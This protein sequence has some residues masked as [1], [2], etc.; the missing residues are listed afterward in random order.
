M[1]RIA[2][3]TLLDEVHS[4]VS[5]LTPSEYKAI[6]D[7]YA[8]RPHGYMFNPKYKAKIWDGYIRFFSSRGEVNIKLLPDIIKILKQ[9]GYEIKLIDRR[10]RVS[11]NVPEID[12]NYLSEFGWVLGDHQVELVNALIRN[13]GGIVKAGTGAG[14]TVCCWILHHLY[15]T[16]CGFRTLIIVPKKS[17]VKQ[18]AEE[19]NEFS[20]DVG[21]WGDN[22][23]DTDHPVVIS[24]WQTLQKHETFV[25]QF[26]H[27]ILDEC[28]TGKNFSGNINKILNKYGKQCYVK[29]GMTGTLPPDKCDMKTLNS[30]LGD[31]IYE[32]TAKH[33]IDIGWLASME[34][35]MIEL[36]EEFKEKYDNIP[37]SEL[38]DPKT[39]ERLTFAK[40]MESVFPE[41]SMER[42]YLIKQLDRSVYIANFVKELLNRSRNNNTIILV[43]NKSQGKIL[44]ELI[45][46]SYYVDGTT[47]SGNR[48]KIFKLFKENNDIV[49]I[50]IFSLMS[51]GMS[52]KRVFNIIALDAEKSFIE[53]IQTIGRGLRKA[54]DKN[55]VN[56]YDIY[57]NLLHAKRHSNARK[58]YYVSEGH[59]INNMAKIKYKGVIEHGNFG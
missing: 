44:Q 15:Y 2:T 33:L 57:S 51:T 48:N 45:P 40:Y 22:M 8:E 47:S 41:Y 5:G 29:M 13:N 53:I 43:K 52:I 35:T 24:T 14:K 50:S 58:K 16:H 59:K 23:R 27:I 25:S 3:I 17:L 42:E 4:I 6:S 10:D 38:I 12:K 18:T 1:S 34:L 36:D 30:A 37:D 28:H 55:L 20:T 49:L 19:F 21:V 46:N 9:I 26:K 39:N 7:E 32:V 11:I 54:S 56:I 31:V